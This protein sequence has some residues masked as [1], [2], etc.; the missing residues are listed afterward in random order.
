MSAC[1]PDAPCSDE[2]LVL[3]I[4][5]HRSFLDQGIGQKASPAVMP[6]RH[7]A[8]KDG[9]YLGRPPAMVAKRLERLDVGLKGG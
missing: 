6:H 7:D 8:D 9:M 4:L 5:R 3:D 2:K 1:R